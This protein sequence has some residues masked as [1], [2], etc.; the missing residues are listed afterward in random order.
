[1]SVSDIKALPSLVSPEIAFAGRSNVGKS[2]LINSLLNRKNLVKTGK[3]PGKTRLLNF[4]SVDGKLTFVDLPG[5]GY[6]KVSKTEKNK[7]TKLIDGY[8]STDNR[9]TLCFL[10]IDIR[11]EVES[12]E[13]NFLS[14]LKS[15]NIETEIIVTK[16]DKVSR[17]RLLVELQKFSKSLGVESGEIIHYSSFTGA[18]KDRVWQ[19]IANKTGIVLHTP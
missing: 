11:R 5:F 3:T 13:E 15:R 1:M 18:G 12:L 9:L 7:W 8:L 4:F 17:N 19:V 10:L 14:L 6:A 16:V 2:S